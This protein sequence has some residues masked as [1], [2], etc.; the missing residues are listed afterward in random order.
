[1]Q[2]IFNTSIRLL[3]KLVV[4]AT[5]LLIFAGA[6]IKSHEVG[7][8]VPDW[9]TSYGKQMFSFPLSEMVGGIFYEHGHR[10]FATIVGFL[11]LVLAVL[12]GFSNQP[13][14]V[15]KTS[16]L[17]LI[18]VVSQGLL[19]GMTVLYFLP[20]PISILHGILAQTFFALTIF[21]SYSQSKIRTKK[22]KLSSAPY[23]RRGAVILASLVY[24]QLILGALMRHTGSG[25]AIPDFPTMGGLWFPSFSEATI[26]NI[27]VDLFDKNLDMVNRWQVVIHFLHRLGA[28]VIFSFFS[29]FLFKFF[30][31]N[32]RKSLEL[33]LMVLITTIMLFQIGLGIATVLTERL[34]YIAS[35][36]VVVGAGLLGSC[37]LLVLITQSN[38]L[39]E[40]SF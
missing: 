14:W 17:A 40:V 21:I 35:F 38:K 10:V 39:K 19:G 3:S 33:K 36:H 32:K 34:P 31:D 11:T 37:I 29:V 13:Q 4:I 23:M 8:S 5:L 18:L 26:N 9:P 27:N 15:K 1:M 25:L 6:L 16:L 22:Q 7:L 12:I 24:F 28:L 2:L 30:K 20:P